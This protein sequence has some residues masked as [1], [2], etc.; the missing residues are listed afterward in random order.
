MKAK[1]LILTSA[2]V[3]ALTSCNGLNGG[4]RRSSSSSESESSIPSSE[5]SSQPESQSSQ[6]SE[7]SKESSE[8]SKQSDSSLPGDDSSLPSS[9]DV[10]SSEGQHYDSSEESASSAE[11]GSSSQ[12]GEE[13][14]S[15]P[16]EDLDWSAEAKAIMAENLYGVILPYN[17]LEETVVYLDQQTGQV[18]LAGGTVTK[19]DLAYY[20]EE[21]G[22]EWVG[23][24]SQ[25]QNFPAGTVYEFET[26]VDT[27][28]G[29]RYVSYT[30][31]MVDTSGNPTSA[32][33][34][35]FFG[36]AHDPYSYTYPAA[37]AA[38]F[39]AS[40]GSQVLPPE[41]EADVFE[42][43][44]DYFMIS[45][46]RENGG[47]A[48]SY[49]EACANAGW[50]A[51]PAD[52][53][54]W[55]G[56]TGM[57]SPDGKYVI[58][59]GYDASYG[60]FDCYFRPAV[61]WPSA[62]ISA[63]FA[64][65]QCAEFEIPTYAGA[66]SY[67]F[68]ADADSYGDPIG[69][70]IAYGA[71]AANFQAYLALL[72]EEGWEVEFPYAAYPTYAV[73]TRTYEGLGVAEIDVYYIAQYNA[74]QIS[75]YPEY[76]PIPAAEWPSEDIAAYLAENEGPAVEIPAYPAGDS[77]AFYED[78]D[79]DGPYAYIIARGVD[80]DDFEAY[81]DALEN[82]GWDVVFP[83][84][85][86]PTYAVAS[87][88]IPEQ[89]VFNIYVYYV[90]EA[91]AVQIT[92]Y[93]ALDDLP[94]EEWPT[95]DIAAFFAAYEGDEFEIPAVDG[96]S[97]YEFG[98][99]RNNQA[100]YEYEM[101]DYIVGYVDVWDVDEEDFAA[102]VAKLIAAGWDVVYD[103]E[104]ETSVTATLT[105]EGEGVATLYVG[106]YADYGAIEVQFNPYLSPLP[107]EEW[108][109]EQLAEIYALY[110]LTDALPAYTEGNGYT[111][112][113]DM[114]GTGVVVYVDADTEE[115]HIAAYEA[116]LVEAGWTDAGTDAYGDTIYVSPNEE[117]AVTVYTET[118]GTF[119][120]GFT[121]IPA[122]PTVWP[123]EQISYFFY[124]YDGD[125]FAIPEI[126]GATTYEFEE[127]DYNET[128]YYYGYY[129]YIYGYIYA[130]GLDESDFESYLD[131]LEE[132]GWTVE[133]DDEDEYYAYATLIVD[134]EYV[135][136]IEIAF[137]EEDE[138]IAIAFNP[139]VSAL[140][141]EG[142]P[143]EEVA[144]ALGELA[145]EI[146]LLEDEA[147]TGYDFYAGDSLVEIA[148][149]VDPDEAASLMSDYVAALTEAGFVYS[150]DDN[151]GDAHYVNEDGTLDVCVWYYEKDSCVV[152]DI[153]PITVTEPAVWPSDAVE[154]FY[155]SADAIPA[156]PGE[157]VEEFA[158]AEL[159]EGEFRVIA[160][161]ST[162]NTTAAYA[163]YVVALEE[164]GW[165][166]A[167]TDKYGDDHYVNAEGTLDLC[168]WY[169]SSYNCYVIDVI[170][171]AEP[172]PI[173][174][175]AED[176]NLTEFFDGEA[177]IPAFEADYV[178][179][180]ETQ[181][182]SDGETLN[183]LVEVNASTD[184]A[185]GVAAYQAALEEAGYTY[186]YE[187]RYGDA[188]Y[189]SEDGLYDVCVYEYNYYGYNFYVVISVTE[190][191]EPVP[192][193]W[194]SEDVAEY[195]GNSTTTLPEFDDESVFE[196]YAFTDDEEDTLQIQAYVSF[197]A[198][199]DE[200]VSDYQAALVAAGWTYS[201]TDRD[202]VDHYVSEDGLFDAS[203][204]YYAYYGCLVIDVAPYEEPTPAVWPAEDI[205]EALGDLAENLPTYE[206]DH[207]VDYEAEATS[208]GFRVSIYLDY[209]ESADYA[210]AKAEYEE[211]LVEAGW[212]LYEVDYFGD[213]T[214]I[215]PDGTTLVNVW[216]STSSKRII[217]D[218]SEAPS[219]EWAADDIA[220]L[221][222]E[223]A[224][225]IPALEDDSITG[226]ESSVAENGIEIAVYS[227]AEDPQDLV[228][229]Y[230]A[231]LQEA[232]FILLEVDEY[233]DSYYQSADGKIIVS[234]YVWYGT[235]Y[236]DIYF[237][238]EEVEPEQ[239][240]FP[241]DAVNEALG[242]EYSF[243]ELVDGAT[244]VKI[245]YVASDASYAS[246]AVSVEEGNEAAWAEAYL[247]ALIDADYEYAFTDEYYNL[248]YY[249]DPTNSFY[250]TVYE[251]S[252]Y[253]AGVVYIE[254]N[255]IPEEE[256]ELEEPVW[257]ADE[258]AAWAA[259]NN[260]DVSD[261]PVYQAPAGSTYSF[262]TDEE[263]AEIA[264]Q[265]DADAIESI[266]ADYCAQ[267][268]EAGWQYDEYYECYAKAYGDSYVVF[269][270][271]YSANGQVIISIYIMQ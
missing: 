157:Y 48:A 123:A 159:S 251:Y 255:P 82:A 172:E 134:E 76:A 56:F 90:E 197:S 124:Y 7:E 53:D 192:A 185:T 214:W 51:I 119:T 224:E 74:V 71:T 65:N 33:S 150:Y 136:S 181:I 261:L 39:A 95:D 247:A 163:A 44:E 15:R 217:L 110:E 25:N 135:A 229:A 87:L 225:S 179:S 54:N 29:T 142:W 84:S 60:S 118:A 239:A 49:A 161:L 262:A 206:S 11:E 42:V 243:V 63:F 220:E 203:V 75:F 202:G 121:D 100:Y 270:Y 114:W 267:L 12:G 27:L 21:F 83:Y 242:T 62:D 98:E 158:A 97:S 80:G 176:E 238:P 112:Y 201:H 137:L 160:Y 34:G 245:E 174:W 264:F 144:E 189:V 143:A 194:P 129:S 170:P 167:Y 221:F 50:T 171:Y 222:P 5:S 18:V 209:T 156:F 233:G 13:S 257:P 226:Y 67:M 107:S 130:Y 37:Y 166:Y 175:P 78:E 77:F 249:V 103:D 228:D 210:S 8:E 200:L 126:E 93:P 116:L 141:A 55:P 177:P 133:L 10:S 16:E 4:G 46:Y 35:L 106:Y 165:T 173:V 186:A 237:A 113:D 22:E 145:S 79:E 111:I 180:Y 154:E 85:D 19:E 64:E 216:S 139:Y 57:E 31:A 258:I 204:W 41:F 260:A 73:A 20:A 47:I 115:D 68:E 92:F 162:Q 188:H 250:I 6:S 3:L 86:Y 246:I 241:A 269:V 263:M 81:L 104:T 32:R 96:G 215:S 66:S 94:S 138:A 23:G 99:G 45:G 191:E 268:E 227:S 117:Y 61:K 38:E 190:Y 69:Y 169:Y 59:F 244:A 151:Y 248:D 72:V 199:G 40:F 128:Y 120:I 271:V 127:D 89:G 256:P 235:I 14:S 207:V 265:A 146:P 195:F 196:L 254:V 149:Y 232:G 52:E 58:W 2:A 182:S 259:E 30:F 101:Y 178:A 131:D 152:I 168:A 213:N 1:L 183:I 132:A 211:A 108:P 9:E 153:T 205:A 91:G 24:V 184:M 193:V 140:P 253:F 109:A 164:A 147:I 26:E 36:Y 43:Y 155:G 231:A 208:S 102:Y 219:A 230:N 266:I 148:A 198:D 240:S 28:E 212:T 70:I 122:D 105:V 17:Y 125:E 88:T 223:Y 218:F 252:E 234:A 187:D 236:V